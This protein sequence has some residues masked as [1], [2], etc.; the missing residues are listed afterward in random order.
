MERPTK[1]AAD[2]LDPHSLVNHAIQR[3]NSEFRFI[4]SIVPKIDLCH[5]QLWISLCDR[6]RNQPLKRAWW[7]NHRVV[8]KRPLCSS[9]R[10]PGLFKIEVAGFL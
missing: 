6:Q 4:K 9:Y 5:A 10:S 7:S 2:D 3:F 8:H 1:P